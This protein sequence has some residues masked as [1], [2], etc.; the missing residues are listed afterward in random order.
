MKI[1]VIDDNE[2]DQKIILRY[3]KQEGFTS[4]GVA[5]CGEEGLEMARRERPELILI[6]TMMPGIDG[7]AT[8]RKIKQ[9]LDFKTKV[10]MMTGRV[11]AVDTERARLMGADEYCVK[12]SDGQPLLQAV[13][14]L[15][16]VQALKQKKEEQVGE[17]E[18]PSSPEGEEPGGVWGPQKAQEAIR[19]L[20]RELENKNE[21]L[22]ALDKL[23]SKFIANVSH[24]LKTPLT[25][26]NGAISQVVSG[27]YGFVTEEQ[28]KKLI[29]A[30]KSA[31]RLNLMIDDLLDFAKL[32]AKQVRLS[33]AEI[34]LVELVREVHS[35]FY[36]LVREKGLDLNCEYPKSQIMICADRNRIIQVFT[37]L[38]GN[39]LKFTG[40]GEIKIFLRET[41]DFIECKVSD[42]GCGISAEDLPKIFE[43]FHQAGERM[44]SNPKGTGLGLSICK[45][46][47]DLHHGR[48]WAESQENQGTAF[49]FILP[50]DGGPESDPTIKEKT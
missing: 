38:I 48:I 50:K 35:S 33:K 1:L 8:C 21:E 36:G 9:D 42:T 40:K 49:I 47:I 26:I 44:G 10:V 12:T 32:E 11:S 2:Q 4:F 15:V 14:R 28:R 16:S 17:S 45:E 25:I 24:E 30:L 46:I 20:S 31:E 3:L 5:S 41:S 34:N 43:R 7:F 37:N 39:A 23:K 6:D 29:M 18:S 22:K 27:I 19:I 13:R